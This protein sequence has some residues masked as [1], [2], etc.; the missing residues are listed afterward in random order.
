MADRTPALDEAREFARTLYA[1]LG[2]LQNLIQQ[3][4]TGVEREQGLEKYRRA[5]EAATE[6]VAIAYRDGTARDKALL[7]AAATKKGGRK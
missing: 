7:L 2:L 1:A 6:L 4:L 3:S 5:V